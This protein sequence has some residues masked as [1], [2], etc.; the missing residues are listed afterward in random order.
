[1]GKVILP[2]VGLIYVD[3]NP[4]IYRVERVEPYW[5]ASSEF[6]EA[7][8]DGRCEAA[9]SELTL[10]E[11]LIKPLRD[12]DADL[13]SLFRAT[14][15]ASNL[16]CLAI[17]LAILETAARLRADHRLKTPDAI[18]AATAIEAGAFLFL[19]NDTD[20]RK[21]PGLNVAILDEIVAQ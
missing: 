20:F 1:V 14:M 16:E 21:V 3:A 17:T 7:I 2:P 10:L 9:T 19:T 4:V 13:E 5:S 18:H 11:V 6:W 15:L 8:D 12:G